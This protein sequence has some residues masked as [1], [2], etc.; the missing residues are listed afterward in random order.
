MG[1]STVPV[2]WEDVQ[3]EPGCAY[4][5]DECESQRHCGVPRKGVSPYCAEH[6]ALCHVAYGSEAEADHLRAVEAIAK[7]VGGRRSRYSVRP[8]G[9]FLKR[10]EQAAQGFSRPRCS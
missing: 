7:V 2:G 9:Q 6:H 1:I 4:I 8:S 5:L 3:D 10:I